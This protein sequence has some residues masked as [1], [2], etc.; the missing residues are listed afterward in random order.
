MTVINYGLQLMIMW[1]ES[2]SWFECIEYVAIPS[3]IG[4]Y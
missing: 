1:N 4:E 3:S 2:I